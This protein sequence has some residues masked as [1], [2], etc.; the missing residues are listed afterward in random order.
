[1]NKQERVNKVIIPFITN[2]LAVALGIVITFAVQGLMD[3]KTEKSDLR[4]GLNLVRKE[5]TSNIE[6]LR[7]AATDLEEISRS[8]Q[9]LYDNAADIDKCPQDSVDYHWENLKAENYLTL[10]DDALQM[11][12]ST[13][14]YS[15]LISR[16][17]SL[18]I[19]RAYDIFDALTR[20]F[21][22]YTERRLT[23]IEKIDDHFMLEGSDL[24]SAVDL[25]TW[26]ASPQAKK[27]LITVASQR[28]SWFERAIQDIDAFTYIDEYLNK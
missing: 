24:N 15:P 5:L 7:Y 10:P 21:N 4:A 1:M 6:D 17:L 27:L 22:N 12:K 13:H 16:E 2:F 3:K 11:L 23:S 25:K 9:Y 18:S 14:L 28:G 20:A 26:L 8:A 19:V